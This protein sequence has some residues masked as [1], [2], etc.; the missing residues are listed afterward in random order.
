MSSRWHVLVLLF[1]IRTAMAFQFGTVGAL[2]PLVG[3]SFQVD[4]ASVGILIGLYLS[5]GLIFAMPGSAIAKFFG[6]KRAVL[7]GLVLM[8]VGGTI[9]TFATTWDLQLVGRA[10]A[11]IGGV[12]LNVLMSKMVADWFHDH[13]IATAMAIF[14]NSWLAGIALAL[15]VQPM[16]AAEVGLAGAF[17]LTA[18][19]AVCAF[20]ALLI[21][22]EG[23]VV[24][25]GTK[26]D[27]PSGTNLT[28]LIV[29][30]IIWGLYNAALA[31]MFAF[32]PIL[33]SGRGWELAAASSMTSLTVWCGALTV[34]ISGLLADRSGRP[35]AIMV[36]GLLLTALA[37]AALPRTDHVVATMVLIGLLGGIPAG[38]ILSL[39]IR[40]LSAQTRVLG[41]GLFYTLLYGFIVF[42][43]PAAGF[44]I[45]STGWDG[46]AMDFGAAMLV[47]AVALLAVF[48]HFASGARSRATATVQP[49]A[50]RA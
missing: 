12:M 22:Y 46:A 11:G 17:G 7:L 25:R 27:M 44:L 18:V 38:A 34:P 30:G 50:S 28:C 35:G 42:A 9:S 32:G 14:V 19:L 45:S 36:I 41:M 48:E 49:S 2:G 31:L 39:P 40:V 20:F 43:P 24:M 29:A 6:D 47:A 8:T 37:M 15:L 23:P 3:Q 4:V 26:G 21:G 33:L 1:L 10:V 16:I 13:E 5:P